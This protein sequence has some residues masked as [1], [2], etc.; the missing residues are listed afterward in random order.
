MSGRGRKAA[1]TTAA[2]KACNN[3]TANKT[4]E[5]VIMTPTPKADDPVLQVF[6]GSVDPD[7]LFG[8]LR[9]EMP[10]VMEELPIGLARKEIAQEDG[11]ISAP[12]VA[13]SDDIAA[14]IT[15]F[16]A[17]SDN[18]SESESDEESD[19][20]SDDDDNDDNNAK[21]EEVTVKEEPNPVKE[22][23]KKAKITRAGRLDLDFMSDDDRS[24]LLKLINKY[25]VLRKKLVRT[26]KLGRPQS[27]GK[28]RRTKRTSNDADVEVV[29]DDVKR[30]NKT[31]HKDKALSPYWKETDASKLWR[32][33]GHTQVGD[34]PIFVL[35]TKNP[36]KH[37]DYIVCLNAA[38]LTPAIKKFGT[39]IPSERCR[40]K[41][42]VVGP[43]AADELH[44]APVQPEVFHATNPDVFKTH[45]MDDT[46]RAL[47]NYWDIALG[48]DLLEEKG[49]GTLATSTVAVVKRG[50]KGGMPPIRPDRPVLVQF[51]TFAES[52]GQADDNNCLGYAVD[53]IKSGKKTGNFFP[54]YDFND[55]EPFHLSVYF[56][57]YFDGK[58]WYLLPQMQR[59]APIKCDLHLCASST[60]YR[61][62]K[63]SL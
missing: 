8:D 3:K 1:T 28:G 24:A 17:L 59:E 42:V 10:P 63:L 31:S 27:K 38:E 48:D 20:E 7:E 23:E 29:D 11:P 18:E 54:L 14:N 35:K 44:M 13:V 33:P 34:A 60:D 15:P 52:E 47:L 56:Y 43:W 51:M 2:K 62:T 41:S 37:A 9:L 40:M 19:E 57:P 32:P 45:D 30:N 5:G 61:P 50:T 12:S 22:G 6:G 53:G 36:V 26:L 49:F 46:M 58:V 55:P 25:P 21:E 39:A 16:K 4:F